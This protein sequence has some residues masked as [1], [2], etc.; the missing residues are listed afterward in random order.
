MNRLTEFIVGVLDVEEIP[1]RME[2]MFEEL[3]ADK[4]PQIMKKSLTHRLRKLRKIQ[5]ENI[6]N[7]YMMLVFPKLIYRFNCI[8]IKIPAGL[9]RQL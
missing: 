2:S 8:P 7:L 9:T 3:K 4:F 5:R 1:D 6:Y